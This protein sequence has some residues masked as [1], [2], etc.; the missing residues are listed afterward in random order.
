MYVL[1][2]VWVYV[3][4]NVGAFMSI[5]RYIQYLNEYYTVCEQINVCINIYV[6]LLLIC[7]SNA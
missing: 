3:Y 7:Q 1:V 4:I 5:Y 2:F 6:V